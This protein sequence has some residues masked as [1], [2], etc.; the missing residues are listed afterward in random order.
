M[1]PPA[2]TLS[3]AEA[4]QRLQQVA[5]MREQLA[6]W[7]A[8]APAQARRELLLGLAARTRELCSRYP[9]PFFREEWGGQ[10]N[11]RCCFCPS[12]NRNEPWAWLHYRKYHFGR[13][14]ER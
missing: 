3:D 13:L 7:W 8:S 9:E 1:P 6:A 5:A 2:R 4:A 11:Y 10:P 12:A 14:V